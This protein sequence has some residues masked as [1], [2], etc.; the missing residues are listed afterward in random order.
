MSTSLYTNHDQKGS[1]Y[2]Q[3]STIKILYASISQYMWCRES[4]LHCLHI[5]QV[6]K[7]NMI[8]RELDNN[9]QFNAHDKNYY[10]WILGY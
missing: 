8:V 2:N 5:I 9:A 4:N 7:M 1:F 3:R 10:I 6:M